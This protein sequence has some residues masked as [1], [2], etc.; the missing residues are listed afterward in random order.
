[1]ELSLERYRYAALSQQQFI[2]NNIGIP[3]PKQLHS[4]SSSS[5]SAPE[6]T[7]NTLSRVIPR[8]P[9]KLFQSSV[10]IQKS[11]LAKRLNEWYF[12]TMTS[13]DDSMN[14]SATIN[15]TLNGSLGK[16]VSTA[17]ISK[18]QPGITMPSSWK[19]IYRASVHGFSA[20]A[21]HK[22]CDGHSPTFTISQ[23]GHV[24]IYLVFFYIL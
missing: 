13:N 2:Q 4:S 23:L 1:M 24:S 17:A 9:P 3:A 11:S 16:S 12:E 20:E 15:N 14:G 10:I 18:S 6:S 5:L 21:F 22:Y 7:T 19:C 8:N